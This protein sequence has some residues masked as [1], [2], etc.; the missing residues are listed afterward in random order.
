MTDQPYTVEQVRHWMPHYD[1]LEELGGLTPTEK[2]WL[3]VIRFLLSEIDWGVSADSAG[4]LVAEFCPDLLSTGKEES[5]YETL[6]RSFLVLK[7]RVFQEAIAAAARECRID[8]S[9]AVCVDPT[10]SEWCAQRI[11]SLKP[12]GG[13]SLREL[14]DEERNVERW[15]LRELCDA[16]EGNSCSQE[17][18]LPSSGPPAF[19]KGKIWQQ[20]FRCN[21]VV[22]AEVHR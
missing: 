4:A 11:E 12:D 22:C 21:C 14:L 17:H 13:K 9:N 1:R 18:P 3:P 2:K 15:R 8:K 6:R 19:H 16:D 7:E 5:S 20:P 10:E